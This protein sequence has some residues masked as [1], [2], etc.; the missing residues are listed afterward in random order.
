[1]FYFDHLRKNQSQ[2][3]AFLAEEVRANQDQC[4][5]FR[6]HRRP[7]SNFQTIPVLF[8]TPPS[9]RAIVRSPFEAFPPALSCSHTPAAEAER[10]PVTTR[11]EPS[12][13][14][15]PVC[16]RLFEPSLPSDRT[17]VVVC[18]SHGDRR[19]D[20]ALAVV[21]RDDA[22]A[23]RTG[24]SSGRLRRSRCRGSFDRRSA[25]T[26]RSRVELFRRDLNLSTFCF[27]QSRSGVDG[28]P[29][30]DLTNR[31]PSSMTSCRLLATEILKL[32]SDIQ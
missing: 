23:C 9:E 13:L 29:S 25:M 8:R 14:R 28:I 6:L 10:D 26:F 11:Y 12:V 19:S 22:A 2:T 7:R 20:S 32:S 15:W 17:A 5:V 18:L 16:R 30:V 31:G 24:R 27:S 21:Y 3:L 1:M 4:R